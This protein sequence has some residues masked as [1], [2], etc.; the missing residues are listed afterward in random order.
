MEK[1]LKIVTKNGSIVTPGELLAENY[2]TN[3]TSEEYRRN[4]NGTYL[5]D[6]KVYSST[7]GIFNEKG[8]RVVKLGG[9][10]IPKEGDYIIGRVIDMNFSNWFID[11]EGPY[12]AGMRISEA[13]K[14]YIDT[15]KY[16]MTHYFDFDDL[17]F[18]KIID[19]T[20]GKKISLTAKESGLGKL[21]GGITTRIDPSKVPRL[22][23]TNESMINLIEKQTKTQIE[24]GHNGVAWIKGEAEGMKKAKDAISLI[25]KESHVKGLTDK[26]ENMLKKGDKK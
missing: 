23:G 15:D 13:S 22:I 17:L 12:D 8:L 9:T 4:N 1:K 7:V 11:I 16:D 2:K 20:D 3:K 6:D 5:K 21:R 26:I 24:V 14:E 19:I 10:Y 18:A 25:D